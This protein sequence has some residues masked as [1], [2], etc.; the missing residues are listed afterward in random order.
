MTSQTSPLAGNNQRRIGFIV[1]VTCRKPAVR[2][3]SYKTG[4][5]ANEARQQRE[6]NLVEIRKNKCEDNLLKKHREG[7]LLRSQQLPDASQPPAAIEKQA[8]REDNLV[9]IRKN[10]REDNLLKMRR[11]RL[12]LQSQILPDASQ[13]PAAI[14]KR[15]NS[16][17]LPLLLF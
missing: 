13:T 15:S 6:D 7:L 10:K 16:I 1:D 12:L 14:E 11:E 8:G 3:K 9:E 17:D 2:K 5:D 4:V